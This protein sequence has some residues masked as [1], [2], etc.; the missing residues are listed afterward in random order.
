M[1]VSL[2]YGKFEALK[3]KIYDEYG[4]YK[5]GDDYMRPLG[6]GGRLFHSTKS[7][8]KF[9]EEYRALMQKYINE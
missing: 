6:K 7:K 8:E 4:I 5:N 2:T 1:F 9:E 3:F